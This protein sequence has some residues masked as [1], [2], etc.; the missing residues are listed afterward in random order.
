MV[1]HLILLLML[2]PACEANALVS[3]A[4]SWKFMQ[5]V[6]GLTLGEP[7][8]EDRMWSLPVN[9]DVSGR[10]HYS[11]K[12]ALVNPGIVWIGTMI[13]IEKD[14]IYLTIDTGPAMPS[15]LPGKASTV[16]GPAN[17]GRIKP[18]KYSVLYR[19][20]DAS[21]HLIGSVDIKP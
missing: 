11:T 14:R 6:G 9:C 21:D 7:H 12:P 18:G 2:I 17:L 3:T 20:P 5:S 19:N 8:L 4:Q 13:E 16:C 15:S 10:K 1:R